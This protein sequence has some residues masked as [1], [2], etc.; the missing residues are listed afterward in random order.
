MSKALPSDA[1]EARSATESRRM[2]RTPTV[3]PQIVQHVLLLQRGGQPRMVRS[4]TQATYQE[5]M[6]A[7]PSTEVSVR[8]QS[9]ARCQSPISVALFVPGGSLIASESS[10]SQRSSGHRTMF[11][12]AHTSSS[13]AC[14]F[15]R[16]LCFLWSWR[17]CG[18]APAQEHN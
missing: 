17:C 12:I 15:S 16:E 5:S 8:W 14:A 13:R 7:T 2:A 3:D 11:H 6:G 1:R 9:L 4:G 18:V 10:N